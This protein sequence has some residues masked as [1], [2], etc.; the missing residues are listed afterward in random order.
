MSSTYIFR[1]INRIMTVIFNSYIN[2]IK[3]CSYN[4]YIKGFCGNT[5]KYFCKPLY[6]CRFEF[7]THCTS[8]RFDCSIFVRVGRFAD[9]QGCFNGIFRC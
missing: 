9:L 3:Q 5:Y 6:I 7:E 4:V 1:L 2:E 8:Y